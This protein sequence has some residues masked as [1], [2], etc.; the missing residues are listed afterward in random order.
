MSARVPRMACIRVDGLYQRIANP[1]GLRLDSDVSNTPLH[2]LKKSQKKSCHTHGN[3]Y[4][5]RNSSSLGRI[6]A[7]IYA[8]SA[9]NFTVSSA[10]N[11]SGR[12]NASC[13]FCPESE[14]RPNPFLRFRRTGHAAIP[15]GSAVQYTRARD[16][17]GDDAV[18]RQW[19]TWGPI[20][21]RQY[22]T[23]GGSAFER[24]SWC[25]PEPYLAGYPQ[26]RPK[27]FGHR[28]SYALVAR[29]L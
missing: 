18:P 16:R 21:R 10:L 6:H 14:R 20:F 17:R 5:R 2:V 9:T 25:P 24:A 1:G 8:I 12:V 3:C 11:F 7:K 29:Y 26:K 19:N 28:D 15:G 4:K 23:R 22:L 27:S 13:R